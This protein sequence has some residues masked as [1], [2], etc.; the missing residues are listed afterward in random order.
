MMEAVETFNQDKA[1]FLTWLGYYLKTA[2]SDALGIR[3]KR[4]N[5]DPINYAASLDAPLVDGEE[6]TLEDVTPDP[7]E[8]FVEADRRIYLEQLHNEL[9]LAFSALPEEESTTL[10]LRF[11]GGLSLKDAAKIGAISPEEARKREGKALQKLRRGKQAA[12]LR[13]YVDDH[14]PFY[15]TH[16]IHSVER[17][18]I[19][20]ERL[21]QHS[22]TDTLTCP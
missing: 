4:D 19:K 7:A 5:L 3:T 6:A 10:R 9:E 2:F 14:T 21:E 1:K 8:P 20:R 17:L 13:A 15:S 18:V 11:Y 22:L 12:R 16:G